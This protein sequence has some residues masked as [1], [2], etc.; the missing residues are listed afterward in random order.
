MFRSLKMNLKLHIV[1]ILLIVFQFQENV[2]SQVK[3]NGNL[4]SE[5]IG[6]PRFEVGFSYYSNFRDLQIGGFYESR[7]DF[8]GDF[9]VSIN[10]L[11]M[12]GFKLHQSY[13]QNKGE[14]HQI[15]SFRMSGIPFFR[16]YFINNWYCETGIGLG[17]GFHSFRDDGYDIERDRENI[18]LLRCLI[19]SGY[20]IHLTRDNSLVL[21]PSVYY[22]FKR[23]KIPE[24]PESLNNSTETE[25][26]FSISL[27]IHMYGTRKTQQ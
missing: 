20:D 26:A 8:S 24:Y 16:Y 5:N 25:F 18:H 15:Q 1:C 2:I 10:P 17:Y 4:S 23:E 7:I 14:S 21:R 13:L 22:M 3:N 9:G 6:L 27:I 12:V 19:A 11:I